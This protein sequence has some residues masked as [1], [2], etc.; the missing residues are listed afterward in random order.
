MKNLFTLFI[1]ISFTCLLLYKSIDN[2]NDLTRL[3]LS[4]PP[5]AIEVQEVHEKNLELIYQIA[6]FENPIYLMNL[7]QQPEYQHLKPIS[8]DAIITL[9]TPHAPHEST[10]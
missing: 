8:V 10:P 7:A 2:L 1:C 6:V 5:L 9:A 3:Q 4:L